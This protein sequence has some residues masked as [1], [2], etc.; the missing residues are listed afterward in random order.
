M[1]LHECGHIVV[2]LAL[3]V[4]IKRAGLKWTKGIFIVR[5]QGT[6]YQNLLVSLAGP[7][8]NL[9]LVA[10]EPWFPLFSLA[11]VCCVI[12]NMVPIE[13]SDGF[14]VASCW[15]EIRGSGLTS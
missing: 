8:V 9:L 2:A 7:S 11:N 3:G 5:E 12:A 13:G 14:R 15:R 6:P 4:K 1:I 10:F